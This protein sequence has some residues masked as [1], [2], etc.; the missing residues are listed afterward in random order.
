MTNLVIPNVLQDNMPPRRLA[1]SQNSQANDD[2]PPPL[3]GLPPMNVKKLY[4]YLE[5]LASLVECQ[6]EATNTQVLGQSSSSRG[7]SFD[8]LKKLCPSYFFGIPYPTKAKTWI[9][10]MKK[11]F[12]IT[13][14]FEEKKASYATFML[15]KEVNHWWRMTKRLLKDQRPIIWRQFKEALY[16]YIYI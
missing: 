4:R 11:F 6:A 10:K 2:V 7:N 3:E 12:D 14:C 9:L 13:D 15:D 5:T 16:I 1:S 8:D